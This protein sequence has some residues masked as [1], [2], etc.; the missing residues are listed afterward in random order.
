V[1]GGCLAVEAMLV[2]MASA[3][4]G[5]VSPVHVHK[6][7]TFRV[8]ATSLLQHGAARVHHA[9]KVCAGLHV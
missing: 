8:P 9:P 6:E 4:L 7:R 1:F 2:D 3:E 5:V